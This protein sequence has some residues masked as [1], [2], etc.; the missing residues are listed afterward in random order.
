MATEIFRPMTPASF[1]FA[2]PISGF[3]PNYAEKYQPV[4]TPYTP[5][6][7]IAGEG[8]LGDFTNYELTE[9]TS[10]CNATRP[11]FA[12]EVMAQANGEGEFN[13]WYQKGPFPNPT[14]NVGQGGGSGRM[15][16]DFI[17]EYRGDLD[18]P[19]TAIHVEIETWECSNNHRPWIG[20]TVTFRAKVKTD[21]WVDGDITE[22]TYR[23]IEY[24]HECVSGD[25]ATSPEG[26]GGD[27]YYP[28]T[29]GH[30]VQT[31]EDV[32]FLEQ[33]VVDGN[34]TFEN[35]DGLTIA[36]SCYPLEYTRTAYFAEE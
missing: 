22:T 31:I 18:P 30:F 17:E 25:F 21:I 4:W 6:V 33:S 34:G 2:Y 11:L 10:G 15:T 8:I 12:D 36:N 29:P 27:G 13:D 9:Y 7:N 23:D 16:F 3:D 28:G 14:G 20:Q 5:L 24:V 1:K 19:G 26:T 32:D 35:F